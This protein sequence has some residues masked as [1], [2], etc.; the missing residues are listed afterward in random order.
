MGLMLLIGSVQFYRRF[1]ADAFL[2]KW[3]Y[4]FEEHSIG[5]N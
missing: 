4:K 3:F 1:I 2:K 5:K